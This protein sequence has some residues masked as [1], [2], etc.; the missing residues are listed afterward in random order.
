MSN[1]PEAT[2]NYATCNIGALCGG[3]YVTVGVCSNTG[4]SYTGGKSVIEI[5]RFD[6]FMY[7]A[8]HTYACN[9][10]YAYFIYFICLFFCV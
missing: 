6:I 10:L 4:G 5:C 2:G 8:D 9:L 3:D 1:A 7:I